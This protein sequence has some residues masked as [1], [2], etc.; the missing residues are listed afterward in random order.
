[1]NALVYILFSMI[2]GMAIF[3][4]AFGFFRIKIVDYWKEIIITNIVISIGTYFYSENIILS[5]LS[6]LLNLIIFMAALLFFFRISLFSSFRI[7]GLGFLAQTLIL[8]LVIS[9]SCLALNINLNELKSN[10]YI[11]YPVQV[12]GDIGTIALSLF[13]R[14]KRIWMTNLPY[15]YSFKFKPSRPNM[16]IF[17]ATILGIFVISKASSI[18]NI[19]TGL[20]FWLICLINLLFMEVKKEMRGEID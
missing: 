16:L 8:G 3:F 18:D 5:N 2:D 12:I 9:V 4:F 13:L 10:D 7:A 14:K 20:L 1:M 17:I 15:S 11:K 19:Y 6:P